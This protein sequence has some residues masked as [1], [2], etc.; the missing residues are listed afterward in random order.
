LFKLAQGLENLFFHRRA[1][2]EGGEGGQYQHLL[3]LRWQGLHL[4]GSEKVG[5]QPEV[6]H[7]VH[8]HLLIFAKGVVLEFPGIVPERSHAAGYKRSPSGAGDRC[9]IGSAELD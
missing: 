2:E 1:N 6:G 7:K 3:V 4:L 9:Q 8:Y 5:E